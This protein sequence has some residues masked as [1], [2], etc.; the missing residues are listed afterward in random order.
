MKETMTKVLGTTAVA[1]LLL[2]AC[3]TNAFDTGR[4][5]Y[6]A[7]P[8]SIALGREAQSSIGKNKDY[9]RVYDSCISIGIEN[10]T[11]DTSNSLPL[12]EWARSWGND[13]AVLLLHNAT[14]EQ[15]AIPE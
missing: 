1:V 5:V 8:P 14:P 4:E 10:A 6:M 7:S 9:E 11:S 12:L 2:S 3:Q 13:E 15:E